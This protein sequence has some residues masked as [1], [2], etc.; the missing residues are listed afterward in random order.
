[1]SGVVLP[2]LALVG[3]AIVAAELFVA[4]ALLGGFATRIAAVVVIFLN[5]NYMLAKGMALWSPASNDA[6][7]VMLALVVLFTDPG[8]VFGFDAL[9][10]RSRR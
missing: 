3:Y 5:L 9:R 7:D 6:A 8:R 1:L 10:P 4:V 2:H